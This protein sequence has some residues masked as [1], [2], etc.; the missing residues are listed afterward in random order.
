MSRDFV[1]ALLQLNAEKQVSRDA[2]VHALE[3]GIQQAYR[4]VS[5]EEDI[6]VRVEPE[7]GRI[8]VYR[9]RHVVDDVED[10]EIEVSVDEARKTKADARA[11]GSSRSSSS[12]GST[13][14]ASARRPPS[15]SSSSA[16]ARLSGTRSSTSSR[17]ARAS[18]SRAP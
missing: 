4:R 13:S 10:P 1:T 17:A 8:D 6:F 3:D 11:S 5:G 7:S 16:F 18:S 9:G 2:L 14:A 12:T 15:R